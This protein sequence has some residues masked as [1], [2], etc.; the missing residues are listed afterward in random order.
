MGRG[1]RDWRKSLK[2]QKR[3]RKLQQP[4]IKGQK[5]ETKIVY[6]SRELEGEESAIGAS[7]SQPIAAQ[8]RPAGGG[9]K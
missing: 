9:E 3:V 1:G 7:H 2:I 5:R 6:K 8:R 4:A